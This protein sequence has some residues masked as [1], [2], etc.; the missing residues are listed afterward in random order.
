[1]INKLIGWILNKK[2]K[3]VSQSR[4]E[5][6]INA[7]IVFIDRHY[8]YAAPFEVFSHSLR[9]YRNGNDI[10]KYEVSVQK[11]SD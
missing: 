10:G 9:V 4:D 7:T 6:L 2:V 8:A 5:M 1:M 11:V 3:Q